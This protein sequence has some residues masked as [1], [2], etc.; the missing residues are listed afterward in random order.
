MNSGYCC[1]LVR[2]KGGIL[3]VAIS[4]LLT[5]TCDLVASAHGS[6]LSMSPCPLHKF[7]FFKLLLICRR[8]I[9][10]SSDRQRTLTSITAA[11]I[12]VPFSGQAGNHI[13]PLQIAF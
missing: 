2:L 12:P 10:L 11:K 9:P 3:P 4:I 7:P 5:K 8:I 13:L 6:D 1:H